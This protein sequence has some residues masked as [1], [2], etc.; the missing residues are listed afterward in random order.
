MELKDIIGSTSAISHR[1]ASLAYDFVVSQLNMTSRIEI[2]FADLEDLSSAFV[3]SWIG[4]LYMNYDPQVLDN[5][6]N[7]TNLP[8]DGIWLTKLSRAKLLGS[9]ESF[10]ISHLTSLSDIL[11]S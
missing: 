7:F 4:K 2:S 1:K 10:R 11:A 9:N 5:K 3:N 6:V 8:E